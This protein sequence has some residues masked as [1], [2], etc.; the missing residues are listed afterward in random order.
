MGGGLGRNLGPDSG[1]TGTTCRFHCDW[2]V[3]E[4]EE[5][6]HPRWQVSERDGDLEV[7]SCSGRSDGQRGQAALTW[8]EAPLGH[9]TP[10]A[11]THPTRPDT[12][13][14]PFLLLSGCVRRLG[15]QGGS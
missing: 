1:E 5:S 4:A 6:Q 13:L 14:S 9:Q 3:L 11:R 15:S 12:L 8:R 2:N 10:R 7:G